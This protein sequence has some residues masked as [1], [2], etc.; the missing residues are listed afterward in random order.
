MQEILKIQNLE[1]QYPSYPGLDFPQLLKGINLSV[2]SGDFKIILG[3]PE[4]GKSTLL[5]IIL[6]LIPRYTDGKI[7]GPAEYMGTPIDQYKPY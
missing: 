2:K 1:Y 5:N 6:S 7:S 3:K 4:S